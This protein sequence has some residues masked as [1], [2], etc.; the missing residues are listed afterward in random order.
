[1]RVTFE[2]SDG[3]CFEAACAP[4]ETIL[5]AAR[6]ADVPVLFQCESGSCGT[7]AARLTAGHAAMIADKPTSLLPAEAADGIRL[8]CTCRPQSDCTFVLDYDSVAGEQQPE[9]FESNIAA[10]TWLSDNAVRVSL[11]LPA[12]DWFEFVPGQFVQV[13]VPGTMAW[14]SYSMASGPRAMPMLDL[15]VRVLPRGVMSDYL[16][17]EAEIGDLVRLE[18]PFGSFRL[19][20][21]KAPHVFVAGGTGLA[22]FLSMLDVI[23]TYA[24]TKP[25]VSLIFGCADAANVFCRE[26]L[27][28]AA[29]MLP[30]LTTRITLDS[31]DG[32][33]EGVLIGT[34][35][36]AIA[37]ADVADPDTTAYVCGPPGMVAAARRRLIELGV[38][39]PRIHAE[40]F[41]PSNIG[42]PA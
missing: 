29:Y 16:R 18:G 27:E 31:A 12:D 41:V 13:N 30:T 5:A 21:S 20:K 23:R 24:G 42:S 4:D 17:E 9:M 37:S 15:I 7:C 28:D 25:D 22:P 36:D 40:Q 1:M 19:Q 32:A 6:R 38:A 3:A 33:P 11:E 26:D 35:V 8:T 14:R 39:G 34:P 2:F 10:L